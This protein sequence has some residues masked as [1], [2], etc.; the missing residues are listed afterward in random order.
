MSTT[1][2]ARCPSCQ[3]PLEVLVGR[4]STA[5]TVACRCGAKYDYSCWNIKNAADRTLTKI[6]LFPMREDRRMWAGPIAQ[7]ARAASLRYER[8]GSVRRDA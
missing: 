6:E 7:A 5:R 2:N 4:K 1:V 8:K 3:A